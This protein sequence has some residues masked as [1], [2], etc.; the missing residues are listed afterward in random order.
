V[1]TTAT[2]FGGAKV[3]YTEDATFVLESLDPLG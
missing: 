1:D 2:A 3:R